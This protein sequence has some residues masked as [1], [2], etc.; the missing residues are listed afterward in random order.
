MET[1]QQPATIG[2]SVEPGFEGVRAAFEQN[3]AEHGDVGAA[4]ALYVGGR[5]VVDLWGGWVD[6]DATTPYGEDTLQLVFSSTKGPTALLAHLLAE[7]GELDIDAPVAEYWPEFAAAGKADVPVRWLLCHKA[8]LPY[9]TRPMSVVD[10]L[11]W[12]APVAALATQEPEWEPGTAHGYHAVTYGWLVGEVIRRVTGRSVGQLLADEVSGP[13]GLE[14]WIGLPDEQQSRVAPL[15]NRGLRR[16]GAAEAAAPATSM[17]AEEPPTL[18]A[19]IEQFLGPD[20]LLI[21]ALGGF[22]EAGTGAYGFSGEGVFNRDD[23]RAAELPAANGV[24]NARSLARL[25]AAVVGTVEGSDRGPLL[26]AEQVERAREVQ[27]QGP[28][29]VLILP[30]TFGLGFMTSSA[31]F[32]YGGATSFGHTGAGGSVSFADPTNGIGFSYVMNRM[33]AG[34]AGDPRSISLI[35]AVYEAIGAEA[36]FLGTPFA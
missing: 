2:G 10:A 20:S 22:I 29:R 32:P 33:Y 36:P 14:F 6:T 23:V 9:V 13:L 18:V 35:R 31:M 19:T 12:E 30:T 1:E 7:R 27:T 28:D 5:K 8:G 25:Y 3:F 34:L 16:R 17:E 24:G 21:K 15:T 11:G 26:S 4:T